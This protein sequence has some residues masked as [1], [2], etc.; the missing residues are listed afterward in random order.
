M[1][2]CQ[3][4]LFDTRS[5]FKDVS[6][7]TGNTQK[8]S[9]LMHLLYP[10]AITQTRITHHPITRGPSILFLF[11][12]IHA[13]FGK[14]FVG[15]FFFFLR[16][17]HRRATRFKDNAADAPPCSPLP[18][19]ASDPDPRRRVARA[20]A[21]ARPQTLPPNR[22]PRRCR[23][24]PAPRLL[25]SSRCSRM[26]SAVTRRGSRALTI[27]RPARRDAARQRQPPRRSRSAALAARPA[28]RRC[29]GLHGRPGRSTPCRR[30]SARACS[31]VR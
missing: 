19:Q 20:R 3:K 15:N 27:A 25:T 23:S 5:V 14:L 7:F 16:A 29:P 17:R 28:L 24:P 31:R 11:F 9:I 8:P 18:C 4:T 13:A 1:T 21:R 10:L 6:K 26:P 12:F 2:S 30:P 22:G